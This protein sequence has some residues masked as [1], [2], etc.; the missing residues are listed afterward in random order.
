MYEQQL[1]LLARQVARLKDEVARKR[2]GGKDG[3]ATATASTAAE[4][5]EQAELEAVLEDG[6]E[7][8]LSDP[9]S[10][11]DNAAAVAA[12]TESP[13]AP[14]VAQ[15]AVAA[16]PLADEELAPRSAVMKGAKMYYKIAGSAAAAA[17]GG[18]VRTGSWGREESPRYHARARCAADSHLLLGTLMSEILFNLA[19]TRS[20]IGHSPLFVL[21]KMGHPISS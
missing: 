16:P 14:D 12:A 21:T 8:A 18:Q 4:P 1:E 13:T 20:F 2:G 9:E 15:V 17:A 19:R 10:D 6:E 3:A 11:E 7:E 5:D